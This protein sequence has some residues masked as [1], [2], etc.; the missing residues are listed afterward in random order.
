MGNCLKC[1][2]FR[3]R[4]CFDLYFKSFGSKSDEIFGYA[5][6]RPS[7]EIESWLGRQESL[8]ITGHF[9]EPITKILMEVEFFDGISGIS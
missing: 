1:G 4:C 9:E 2:Y 3:V 6:T 7:E 5:I 8:C